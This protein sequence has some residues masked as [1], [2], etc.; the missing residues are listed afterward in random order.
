MILKIT[1]DL[2][3]NKPTFEYKKV[4]LYI[5]WLSNS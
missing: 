2:R 3:N 5:N 4:G 1:D